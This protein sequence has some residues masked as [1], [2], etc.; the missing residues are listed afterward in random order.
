MRR[1]ARSRQLYHAGGSPALVARAAARR[2]L[3]PALYALAAVLAFVLP[4]TAWAL[5]VAIPL[6]YVLQSA[7]SA[8][9]SS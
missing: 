4:P 5:F 3:E 8:A 1:H 9:K 6:F 7:G 2:P